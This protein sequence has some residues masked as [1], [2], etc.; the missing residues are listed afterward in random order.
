MAK[1][2]CYLR[3][4]LARRDDDKKHDLVDRRKE[5][6]GS[7]GS[8]ERNRSNQ[9]GER[10]DRGK[11][12]ERRYDFDDDRRRRDERPNMDRKKDDLLLEKK[13]DEEKGRGR[14]N[15]WKDVDKRG[16]GNGRKNLERGKLTDRNLGRFDRRRD[17][18]GEEKRLERKR[19]DEGDARDFDSRRPN[20]NRGDSP[21]RGRGRGKRGRAERRIDIDRG[22][23]GWKKGRHAAQGRKRNSS[24][25][26]E[27]LKPK[28][29]QTSLDKSLDIKLESP[30]DKSPETNSAEEE[31]EKTEGE[32][33][34]ENSERKETKKDDIE[35]GENAE[36]LVEDFS[37]FG[38][39]DEEILNQ[40]DE[41][42]LS[43]PDSSNSN[44]S[45]KQSRVLEDGSDVLENLETLNKSD[46]SKKMEIEKV[47]SIPYLYS[48]FKGGFGNFPSDSRLPYQRSKY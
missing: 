3:K 41:K 38:E 31:K 2:C 11:R 34:I 12:D 4:D 21:R 26:K 19:D 17:W 16:G 47:R 44:K 23:D 24:G 14:E 15:D 22:E 6:R 37:D 1:S 30:K 27:D 43:R 13:R 5:D 25:K 32:E 42:G 29:R 36:G 35:K 7:H 40:E 20:W 48:L 45:D 39:S 8:D 18:E 10:D 46:C 28:S 9:R 33:K